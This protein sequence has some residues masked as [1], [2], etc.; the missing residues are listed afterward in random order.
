M[1][2]NY[3]THS[4]FC[5]G[6]DT[7]EQIV[8]EAVAK[9]FGSIGFS[10]HSLYPFA[11]GWHIKPDDFQRYAQEIRRLKEAYRDRI[12]ILC[13]FEADY[14]PPLSMPQKSLY[15]E[16][17]ADY[18]IGSVHY[19]TTEQGWL[20]VD[21]PV[22]E[23]EHGI[24]TLFHGDGRRLVQEYFSRQREML[25]CCDM[26]IIGHI[27]VIRV[28]NGTL[29][30][31]DESDAWYKSEIKAT[32]EAAKRAGVIVEINTGGIARGT[33]DDTYPSAEFLS[34]LCRL[35]VPITISSDAH[36]AKDLDC[37]FEL[38]ARRAKDAGYKEIVS[39]HARP[40]G[41]ERR[42]VPLGEFL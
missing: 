14:L 35:G 42:A 22:R 30:F 11:A 1:R 23:V 16:L 33:L 12:E 7:P 34:E 2:T 36:S 8:K 15:R 17:E 19:L 21:G 24:R 5:D 37:A 18:L 31:F 29:R 20:T 9:G 40:G 28:R 25:G 27:D 26:D 4:T 13:G 41:T 32:A 39:L 38:A 6:R 10:G 3:H